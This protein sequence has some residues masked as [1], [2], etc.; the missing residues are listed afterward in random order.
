MISVHVFL[1][2]ILHHCLTVLSNV[3]DHGFNYFYAICFLFYPYRNNVFISAH[4]IRK[5]RLSVTFLIAQFKPFV[6]KCHTKLQNR[7][8]IKFI[9]LFQC[10]TILTTKYI[11]SASSINSKFQP[12]S[13]RTFFPH[14]FRFDFRNV[15]GL[16]SENNDIFVMLF[17]A[18]IFLLLHPSSSSLL[19]ILHTHTHIHTR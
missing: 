14:V 12:R 5:L 11:V 8:F 13:E 17:I 1:I 19:I 16:R 15:R 6:S 7:V 3:R 4:G 18:K 10:V 2:R 9:T